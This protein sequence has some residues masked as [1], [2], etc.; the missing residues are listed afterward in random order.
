MLQVKSI[1][2][3]ENLVNNSRSDITLLCN[4]QKDF[5]NLTKNI[6]DRNLLNG[7]VN[8]DK[9]EIR[10]CLYCLNDGIVQ[11]QDEEGYIPLVGTLW[12]AKD[13]SDSFINLTTE[14]NRINWVKL[15]SDILTISPQHLSIKVSNLVFEEIAEYEDCFESDV[16]LSLS[17]YS[18][19]KS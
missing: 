7:K 3:N 8:Y 2:V 15:K 11:V 10:I 4:T 18:I 19:Q 17:K 14:I 5:S 9:L 12:I 1:S 16:K 13:E 6:S